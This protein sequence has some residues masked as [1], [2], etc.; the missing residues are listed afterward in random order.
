MLTRLGAVIAVVFLA[1]G[2]LATFV[3]A[4]PHGLPCGT[5][6]NPTLDADEMEQA[7]NLQDGMSDFMGGID[8]AEAADMADTADQLR[9][10]PAVCDNAL[11]LRLGLTIA[12]WFVAIAG[13]CA[14]WWV[15]G[16]SEA[17]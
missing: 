10:A 16:R 5:W 13:P 11:D 1:A 6:V 3:P 9:A 8:P 12:L 2:C 14:L 15:A 4:T 17:E 7:A